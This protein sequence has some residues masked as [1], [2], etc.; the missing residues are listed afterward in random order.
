M[1]K[2]VKGPIDGAEF[3]QLMSAVWAMKK[4]DVPGIVL[5]VAEVRDLLR[6]YDEYQSAL[7]GVE[8]DLDNEQVAAAKE[9]KL[10]DKPKMPLGLTKPYGEPSTRQLMDMLPPLDQAYR[11]MTGDVDPQGQKYI[12]VHEGTGRP[13]EIETGE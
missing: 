13:V 7:G 3:M 12:D 2:A 5:Y 6:R 11:D 10:F 1:A 9:H 8:A 4:S